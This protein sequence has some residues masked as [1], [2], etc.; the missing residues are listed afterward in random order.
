MKIFQWEKLNEKT[1]K[2]LTNLWTFAA[3]GIF[4]VDFFSEKDYGN[5]STA[6]A[7]IYTAILGIYVGTKEFDRWQ[8]SHS[9]KRFGELFIILWTVLIF[10]FI[11]TSAL[12]EG[13]Y[14]IPSEFSATYIAILSIFAITQKSKYIH[15]KRQKDSLQ[16]SNKSV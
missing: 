10:F 8:N 5:L 9:A 12:T 11:I 7:I 2:I 4:T 1:W 3:M 15:E 16:N 13:K 6:V 14:K